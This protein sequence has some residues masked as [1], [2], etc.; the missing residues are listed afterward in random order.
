MGVIPFQKSKQPTPLQHDRKSG[1]PLYP[2]R[3]DEYQ[4]LH[5]VG[6]LFQNGQYLPVKVFVAPEMIQTEQGNYW[7]KQSEKRGARKGFWRGMAVGVVVFALI[8]LVAV[9]WAK[10]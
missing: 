1:E 10:Y 5:I 3:A 2:Y 4:H 6:H 7:R 8:I 9:L